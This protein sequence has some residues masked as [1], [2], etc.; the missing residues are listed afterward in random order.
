MKIYAVLEL[1]D[2]EPLGLSVYTDDEKANSTFDA[3]CRE[4]GVVE[5]PL[6]GTGKE[7]P[8]TIRLAG[9]DSYSVQMFELEAL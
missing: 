8:G 7:A 6:P 4:N 9:D 1:A 2:I 3:L 5:S